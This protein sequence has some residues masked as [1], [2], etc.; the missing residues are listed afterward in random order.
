M[1]DML[2]AVWDAVTETLMTFGALLV[3]A[4]VICGLWLTVSSNRIK[5]GVK[6]TVYLVVAELL[7]C[8]VGWLGWNC[9]QADNLVGTVACGIVAAAMAVGF[10]IIAIYGHKRNWKQEI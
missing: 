7:A 1:I 10:L 6:T 3:I 9:W 8:F 5:T 4:V 2:Y